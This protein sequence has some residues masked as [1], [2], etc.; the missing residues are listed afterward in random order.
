MPRTE[1]F[2]LAAAAI[3]SLVLRAIAFFRYRFDSDEP[4]HLHVTWAWTQGLIPYRD[5]FDNHM[6]LFHLLTAPLLGLLGE[7]ANILLWMRAF[8]LPLFALVLYCT[9]VLA[10]RLYSRRV[11]LWSVVLL[12]LVPPFFL[13]SLEYRNDNLWTAIW[14][15]VLLVIT[16]GE[17]TARRSFGAGLLLGIALITSVKTA[18]LAIAVGAAVLLTRRATWA[19][20]LAG[21]AGSLIAPGAAA[22]FFYAN[23]AWSQFL[24][25]NFTFNTLLTGSRPGGWLAWLVLPGAIGF[26]LFR[27]RDSSSRAVCALIAVL[28][29]ATVF[30]FWLFISPRD[31]LPVFPLLA[32]FVVAATHR[33]P[34]LVAL[35][36]L[37]L[38]ALAHNA[39]YFQ[40]HTGQHITMM[41]QVLGLTRPGE[42]LMDIKGETIY[43]RRPH[44]YAFENITRELMRRGTIPDTVPEDMIAARCYVSQAE[45]PMYPPRANQFVHE[46]FLDLGRLRAAG[47]W[48]AADG[49]YRIAIPGRY[50][51]VSD[52]GVVAGPFELTAGTQR[53]EPTGERL[54]VLWA[55]AFERG[56]SPFHLRDREF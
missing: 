27:L 44:Y 3:A 20:A 19:N 29:L 39:H 40:N 4:Q 24:W 25:C 49:T 46:H 33:L 50:V 45:G 34:A 13:K 2:A 31:L 21:V 15:I 30:A 14:M 48:I 16:G 56:Y 41:R 6:P 23:G 18:G 47:Q 11:A 55:P 53:I 51:I 35:C 32:I 42:P 22:G 54:A 37:F 43:R 52:R 10:E 38:I 8:M 9:Y 12:S 7:R 1:R 36:A 28:Y 17:F 26:L 5:L